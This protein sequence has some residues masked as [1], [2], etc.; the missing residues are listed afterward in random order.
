M[1]SAVAY[2]YAQALVDIVMASGSAWK[3]EDAV[4]QLRAIEALIWESADLRTAL[5]TPAI[6]NSRKRA[7]MGKLMEPP[8]II[9]AMLMVKWVYIPNL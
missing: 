9:W 6:P 4:A 2:R 1:A 3:P 7:V 8:G 5:E